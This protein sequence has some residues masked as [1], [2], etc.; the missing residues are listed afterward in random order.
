MATSS[1]TQ[2]T[3]TGWPQ[4]TPLTHHSFWNPA[5]YN[6]LRQKAASLL[7][8]QN[9]AQAIQPEDL[10]HDA[11]LRLSTG[12]VATYA[13]DR[14]HFLAIA[15]RIMKHSLYDR[16]RAERAIKRFGKLKRAELTPDIASSTHQR[17]E[18]LWVN[19]LLDK[20]LISNARRTA[21]ARLHFVEERTLAE[22]AAILGVST[23]TIKRDL[24][25][26]TLQLRNEFDSPAKPA[27]FIQ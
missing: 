1:D 13:N 21:V 9:P 15:T 4:T 12:T 6:Q 26:A 27:R 11:Y 10:I 22:I 24:R 3:Q 5:S 20:C 8:N 14:D 19:D 7:R 17:I 25:D 23:R 2:T 18:Y 16:A